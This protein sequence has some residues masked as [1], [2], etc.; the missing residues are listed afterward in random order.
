MLLS[1]NVELALLQTLVP[2]LLDVDSD[3]WLASGGTIA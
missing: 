3:G 1:Y 2:E